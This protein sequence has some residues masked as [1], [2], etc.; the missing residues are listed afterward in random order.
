MNQKS[1]KCPVCKSMRL[2][3]DNWINCWHCTNPKCLYQW[4][5][6]I[7]YSVNKRL[8]TNPNFRSSNGLKNNNKLPIK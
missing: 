7:D 5:P 2:V 8:I 3:H 1:I 6:S 4:H